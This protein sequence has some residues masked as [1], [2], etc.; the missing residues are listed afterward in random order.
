[1]ENGSLLGLEDRESYVNNLACPCLPAPEKKVIH[2][3]LISVGSV[4]ATEVTEEDS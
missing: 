1:M 2:P 3:C 4:I